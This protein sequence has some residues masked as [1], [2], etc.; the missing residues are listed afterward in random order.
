TR[1]EKQAL[2]AVEELLKLP[3]TAAS[4]RLVVDLRGIAGG[5]G[6]VAYDLAALFAV[7]DLGEL[8][9]RGE[10]LSTFSSATTPKWSGRL[11]VLTDAGS[12]GPSEILAAILRQSAD[13]ELVGSRTFGHAGRLASRALSSGA[14]L[15]YSDAFFT[16]PDGVAIDRGLEPGVVVQATRQS[17]GGGG[18]SSVD[19]PLQ[20]ALDL[21]LQ[22]VAERDAA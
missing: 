7:G 5:E 15:F 9:S 14:T 17:L 13:A 8:R 18:G 12:Q 22:D 16:G 4:A 20:R 3:E 1:V 6:S 11:A 21:L 19:V 10:T 2:E